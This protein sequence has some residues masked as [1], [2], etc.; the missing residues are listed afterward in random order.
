MKKIIAI[1]L[2]CVLAACATTESA[3]TSYV[4]A[5]A[6]Y[7]AAFATALQ[8][9]IDGKLSK[10]EVDSITLISSQVTPICTGPLPANPEAATQQVTAAVTTITIMEAIKKA[11]K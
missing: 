5:C 6:A 4:K 11:S 10:S 9:R 8:L 7:N 1:A 3:Q 2:L